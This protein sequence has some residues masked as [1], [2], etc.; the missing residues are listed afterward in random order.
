MTGPDEPCDAIALLARADPTE[1]DGPLREV[2]DAQLAA[3]HARVMRMIVAGEG[4]GT[5]APP[6]PRRGTRRTRATRASA[7][8]VGLAAAAVVALVALPGGKKSG[9]LSL[10]NAA[11]KV[12]A[13]RLPA[14]ALPPGK[15]FRMLVRDFRNVSG[16]SVINDFNV[17]YWVGSDGSGLVRQSIRRSLF[18]GDR[19][20]ALAPPPRGYISITCTN[21]G[22]MI[23]SDF[24]VGPRGLDRFQGDY[25]EGWVRSLP[26]NQ[27]AL[28]ATLQAQW[29][30]ENPYTPGVHLGR[31]DSAQLL[32]LIGT[33]L[34]NPL[35]SPAVR[36]SLFR[37]AGTLPGVSVRTKVRDS[38][39]RTGT[40]ISASG[41]TG[42][43]LPAS[44]PDAH[45]GTKTNRQMYRLIFDPA[46]SLIL[47]SDT[48]VPGSGNKGTIL[49]AYFDQGIVGSLPISHHRP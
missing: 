4:E 3:A 47:D 21:T 15:Y 33:A 6:V 19:C 11:A 34:G 27:H 1:R 46:T 7:A 43:T 30:K 10:I 12:A 29:A 31:A 38:Y 22:N 17:E 36:S 8:I 18:P 37:L 26:T 16:S 28:D 5:T 24:R 20:P 35:T 2:D 40:E 13:R 45:H 48:T 44:A 25:V 41:T 32:G 49:L 39:G 9:E 14:T 23:V 42:V